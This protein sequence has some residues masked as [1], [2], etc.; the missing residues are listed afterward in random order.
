MTWGMGMIRQ[1]LGAN[2]DRVFGGRGNDA[3]YGESGDD[4]LAGGAGDG[5]SGCRGP[6]PICFPA[7]QG[8]TLSYRTQVQ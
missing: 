2:N 4:I 3:L 6:G 1:G 5:L 7:V 8:M